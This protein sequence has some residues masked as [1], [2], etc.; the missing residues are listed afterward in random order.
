MIRPIDLCYDCN[1]IIFYLAK[2]RKLNRLY[3]CNLSYFIWQKGKLNRL[4]FANN[5]LFV[6]LTCFKRDIFKLIQFYN[7]LGM[8]LACLARLARN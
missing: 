6:L 3:D 5:I 2:G 1:F 8:A 4:W 7:L